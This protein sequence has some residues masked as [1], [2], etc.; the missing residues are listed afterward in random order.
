MYHYVSDFSCRPVAFISVISDV[1]LSGYRTGIPRT[2]NP[3]VRT[4]WTDY[5]FNFIFANSIS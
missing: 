2:D 1:V 5:Y 3:A 4:Q